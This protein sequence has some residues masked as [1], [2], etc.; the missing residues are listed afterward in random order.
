MLVGD[1]GIEPDS[2]QGSDLH[3]RALTCG[4]VSI[5]CDNYGQQLTPKCTVVA[6][7]RHRDGARTMARKR[8]PQGAG[9]VRQLAS[10]RWQ[11]RYRDHDHTLKSAPVTFDTKLDASARLAD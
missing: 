9:S 2:P 4:Y 3:K 11:A 7:R 10:G 1:T 5:A 8:R 6:R